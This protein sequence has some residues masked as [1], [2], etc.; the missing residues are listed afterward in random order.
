M[1]ASNIE[2]FWDLISSGWNHF[3]CLTKPS[4]VQPIKDIVNMAIGAIRVSPP[5]WATLK[6]FSNLIYRPY[7]VLW[8]VSQRH[9]SMNKLAVTTRRMTC[10]YMCAGRN[11][12]KLTLEGKEKNLIQRKESSVCIQTPLL[13]YN[14]L[15]GI[16]D[17][18]FL[19]SIFSSGRLIYQGH[20]L[21]RV[22]TLEN[23]HSTLK[24]SE[25]K[26]VKTLER[27]TQPFGGWEAIH[28]QTTFSWL[29]SS[30]AACHNMLSG[31][32]MGANWG[33][34]RQPND[35]AEGIHEFGGVWIGEPKLWMVFHS[36]GTGAGE[37]VFCLP[38]TCLVCQATKP[39]VNN[40][41]FEK[42]RETRDSTVCK[43][44][45]L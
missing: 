17:P 15:T 9:P 16:L 39:H 38:P 24:P 7:I 5:I 1:F 19:P 4:A 33:Q 41:D 40:T 37:F 8:L 23:F 2:G 11:W 34:G 26:R 25:R 14:T 45:H 3:P 20:F 30:W 29:P 10:T 42:E 18:I 35:W 44:S 6:W 13:K 12:R 27:C 22:F 28:Q 21:E 31:C 36:W 43:H 32:Y